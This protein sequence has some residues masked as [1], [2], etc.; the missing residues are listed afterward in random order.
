VSEHMDV[1]IDLSILEVEPAQEYHAKADRFL[2]S[3]QLLDFIKCPWLHRKKCIGLIEVEATAR[4]D[5]SD[6]A[7]L[8]A[9]RQGGDEACIADLR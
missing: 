6:R 8:T 7:E 9:A 5:G 3:H 1:N 2:T 4:T